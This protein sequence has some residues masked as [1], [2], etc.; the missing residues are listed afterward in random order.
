MGD[1]IVKDALLFLD[2]LICGMIIAAA[3][4]VLRI[5]RR[6]VPHMNIIVSIE[7]FIF[8]NASGVYL[9][10]VLF[11]TNDGVIRGFFLGGAIIGAYIYKKSIGEILVEII[12]KVACNVIN[13]LINIFLKK[14]A[15]KVIMFLKKRKEKANGEGCEKETKDCQH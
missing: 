10:A 9:F 14:P 4:D 11:G 3:Y 15:N 2:A 5:Y 7:D 8:W 6:I 1:F 13:F 12:S